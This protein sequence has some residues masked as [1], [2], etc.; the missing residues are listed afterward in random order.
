M[1][2]LLFDSQREK[3]IYLLKFADLLK[4]NDI[5]SLLTSEQAS[6]IPNATFSFEDF[7]NDG[8]LYLFRTPSEPGGGEPLHSD[9]EDAPSAH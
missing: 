3:Q 5:T 6:W 2:L 7:L 9:R 1:F 8:N 4:R